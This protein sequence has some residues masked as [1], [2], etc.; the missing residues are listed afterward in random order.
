MTRIEKTL[1]VLS[2]ITLGSCASMPPPPEG[3]TCIIDATRGYAICVPI[4]SAIYRER[5]DLQ[6]ATYKLPLGALDNYVAFSPDTWK[7]IEG[8]IIKLK[9]RA[10]NSCK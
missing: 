6:D 5:I 9:D 8:Y 4:Q 3:D 1:L 10:Q 2:M 7:S